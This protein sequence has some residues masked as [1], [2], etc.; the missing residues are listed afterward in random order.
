MSSAALKRGADWSDSRGLVALAV[1]YQWFYNGANFIAFKVAGETLH[2]LI[3]ATIRFTAAALLMLPFGLWRLRKYPASTRQLVA[4]GGLGVLMLVGSQALAIWG[5]HFLP[6][7]VA[8]VFGSAAPLFLVLFASTL[9]REPLSKREITGVS[10][11]FV[12]IALM[13]WSAASSGQ[14]SLVGVVMMV[15]ASACWGAGSLLGRRLPLQKDPVVSLSAQLTAASLLLLLV[16]ATSGLLVHA[17]VAHLP[18]GAWGS[19]AFLTIGST[20]IG[21]AVFV[22]L[23]AKVSSTLANTFNY[24]APVIA[25]VLS[26]L[27][28][29]EQI[30]ISKAVAAGIA[31]VGVA[32]MVGG[33]PK[34]ESRAG[35]G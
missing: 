16:S 19:L 9:F 24:V 26:A 3:V 34:H 8:S 17:D 25:L 28:L 15:T 1:G 4:A 23:N 30:T 20:L 29:R 18:T 32:L 22:A 14:F 35:D 2:P 10:V 31:L 27:Y 7:G 6:A 33:S 5:T 21:Y 11:G 13:G 12:G